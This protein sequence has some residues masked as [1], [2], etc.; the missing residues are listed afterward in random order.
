MADKNL[1]YGRLDN[2]TVIHEKPVEAARFIRDSLLGV[3][4][5]ERLCLKIRRLGETDNQCERVAA[6][7]AVFQFVK[8]NPQLAGS[9]EFHAAHGNQ[10]YSYV[11][12]VDDVDAAIASMEKGGAKIVAHRTGDDRLP[13]NAIFEGEG[14]LIDYG[15]ADATALCGL[16]FE[17]VQKNA[18]LPCQTGVRYP[19]D[20][21]VFQHA[22]IVVPDAVAAADFMCDVMGGERTEKTIY[23][24]IS[25]HN[26]P[27][28]HVL[29]G[30]IVY[31]L[32]QPHPNLLGWQEHLDA[33]GPSTRLICYHFKN[34]V[35]PLLDRMT[36]F[37]ATPIRHP[38][39]EG[40]EN[41]GAQE[42]ERELPEADTGTFGWMY[43]PDGDDFDRNWKFMWLDGLDVCGVNWEM[44]ENSYR[45]VSSTGYF[46]NRD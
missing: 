38:K 10:V 14:D 16:R 36:A 4:V 1:R 11:I 43:G 15:M 6:G 39:V 45:W 42:E 27:C 20:P 29:Y 33:V 32:I 31:Q 13:Y 41:A 24:T 46:F 2:I 9:E 35:Q 17:F 37:G 7:G 8:P 22:E 26:A 28:V 25:D 40:V 21:G 5:D 34:D 12:A 23:E 3:N 30:G 19:Q 18:Q 44:L